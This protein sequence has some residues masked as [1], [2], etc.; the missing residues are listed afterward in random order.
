[1]VALWGSGVCAKWTPHITCAFVSMQAAIPEFKLL[2]VGDS[3]VGKTAFL[4]RLWTDRFEPRYVPTRSVEMRSLVFFTSDWGRFR[5]NC[6]DIPGGETD[7][8]QRQGYY[9]QGQ[10]AIIMFDVGSRITFQNA[11]TWHEEIVRV[12]ENIPTVLCGNKVDVAPRR[13]RVKEIRFTRTCSL[14]YFE[15]STYSDSEEQ[16]REPFARLVSQLTGYVSV[17]CLSHPVVPAGCLTLSA[18]CVFSDSL[19]TLVDPP[20]VCGPDIQLT[21]EQIARLAEENSA[22]AAA[23]PLPDEDEDL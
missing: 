5:F 6:W 2:L 17:D 9:A 20:R 16:L 1:M 19:A 13:S 21:A 15:I 10:C 11:S 7:D 22:A 18:A 12:C 8:G 3:G 14:P 4:H 23:V